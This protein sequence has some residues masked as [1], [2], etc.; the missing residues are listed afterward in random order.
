MFKRLEYV[1][2][3]PNFIV[4]GIKLPSTTKEVPKLI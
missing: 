3:T 2:D 1:G 4:E